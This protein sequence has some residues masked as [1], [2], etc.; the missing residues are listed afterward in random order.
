MHYKLSDVE[1]GYTVDADQPVQAEA[2]TWTYTIELNPAPFI[3]AY[4]N[5][6]GKI[7]SIVPD[8]TVELTWTWALVNDVWQWTYPDKALY[9]IRLGHL[10]EYTVNFDANGGKGQMED[11]NFLYSIEQALRD[12]KSV[13]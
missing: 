3:D 10:N 13:V 11:Q 6:Y 8:N 1:N 5:E 9:T 2:G 7:H 4:T 12:R